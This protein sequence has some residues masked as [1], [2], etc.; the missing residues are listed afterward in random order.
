MAAQRRINHVVAD[1]PE[2]KKLLGLRNNIDEA[3][4]RLVKDYHDMEALN[5]ELELKAKSASTELELAR[6]KLKSVH[7]TLREF[8]T[9]EANLLNV[10]FKGLRNPLSSI[11]EHIGQL[12]Q[13]DQRDER[14][15]VPWD[16]VRD[17]VHRLWQVID[18][19]AAVEAIQMGTA[20]LHLEKVNLEELVDSVAGEHQDMTR[21]KGV[22]LNKAVAK[23]LPFVMGNRQHLKSALG[24]LLDNAICCSPL[25]GVVTILANGSQP[26]DRVSLSVVDMRQ[27]ALEEVEIRMLQGLFPGERAIDFE[28]ANIDLGLM[29]ARQII[30]VHKGEI[31]VQSEASKGTV[32]TLTFP[33]AESGA[34]HGE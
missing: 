7:E 17:E 5:Q 21:S 28:V 22:V 30:N 20:Q 31:A 25:G 24:H 32:F 23:E 34:V 12:A 26:G 8:Y 6:S 4:K 10:L 16:E 1:Q 14:E 18:D 13:G 3:L 19:L 33:A 11:E 9:R 15:S 27:V 29:V 2:Q